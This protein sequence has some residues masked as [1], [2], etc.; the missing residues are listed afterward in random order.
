MEF[1]EPQRMR[2][3]IFS[4]CFEPAINGV[5]TSL[6][7]QREA[8]KDLG[9]QVDLFCPSYP[10]PHD[11]DS[12]IFRLAAVPFPLHK[13]EQMT[14]PW[15]PRLLRRAWTQDYDLVHVQTPFTVGLLG[16]AMAWSRRI[17]R[18]FHHHTLWEEY[19]EYL[20]IPRSMT[21]G[22]AIALCRALA[23][24]C[25]RVIAPSERVKNRFAEQGVRRPIDVIPT[26]IRASRF[27]NGTPRPELRDGDEIC[28]YVGRLAF[29][30][31][32]DLLLEVFAEIHAQ[33]PHARLWLVGDGPARGALEAQ[34]R[35]L[36][37]AEVCTFF[38]FVPRETLRDFVASA[39]IFLFT[40]LT[41]TQGLVVLEAQ[42]GGLP[43]V[44]V[45][46]S[47]VD[48]AVADGVGGRLLEPGDRS[49]LVSASL[50]ILEDP[51]LQAQFS[52]RATKWASKFSVE[53]MGLALLQ[54]YTSACNKTEKTP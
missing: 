24:S 51:D 35:D 2:I 12:D 4:D 27:Q 46:A 54:S 42:S 25:Q 16:L 52:E 49:G 26:G 45:R 30:K 33:R 3:A 9:C 36:G 53:A 1:D 37:V 22:L 7:L 32:L 13:A 21:E 11:D 28:L 10:Q 50:K 40:S 43:V 29:E 8:L 44:A 31:S 6:G 5:V 41:E 20:P 38:G 19:V 48:E 15:P 34:A 18:V 23:Q 39:R 47:G 14:F 17:P